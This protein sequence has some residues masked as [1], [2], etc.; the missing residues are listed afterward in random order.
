MGR[1]D[2]VPFYSRARRTQ[3]YDFRSCTVCAVPWIGGLKYDVGRHA[4]LV[5]DR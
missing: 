1:I 4:K 2:G 3:K 5:A